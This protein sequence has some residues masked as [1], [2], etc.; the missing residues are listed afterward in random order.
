MSGPGGRKSIVGTHRIQQPARR[1]HSL[2]ERAFSESPPVFA[3]R[4]TMEMASNIVHHR[5]RLNPANPTRDDS[6]HSPQPPPHSPSSTVRSRHLPHPLRPGC[7]EGRLLRPRAR[8][9]RPG[10]ST[11]PGPAAFP[12]S[13]PLGSVP[14]FRQRH[15]GATKSLLRDGLR[16]WFRPTRASALDSNRAIPQGVGHL[17]VLNRCI[18]TPSAGTNRCLA[19]ERG[20]NRNRGAG[21]LTEPRARTI[22]E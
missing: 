3:C 15:P 10:R 8:F 4:R 6:R 22:G 18:W 13:A 14:C 9:R 20:L 19:A 7:S 21:T 1:F 17:Q 5:N 12:C 16:D 2:A 11:S